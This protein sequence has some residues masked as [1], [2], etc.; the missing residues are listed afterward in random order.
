MPQPCTE[1]GGDRFLFVNII[2]EYGTCLVQG[3]KLD[4]E[5]LWHLPETSTGVGVVRSVPNVEP[6]T[7]AR[8][9]VVNPTFW[10]FGCAFVRYEFTPTRKQGTGNRNNND[11]RRSV[12]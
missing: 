10:T 2:S 11:L 6:A 8:M 5:V 7:S 12:F 1:R 9:Y 4:P 3:R